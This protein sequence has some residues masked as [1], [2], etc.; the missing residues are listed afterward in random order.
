MARKSGRQQRSDAVAALIGAHGSLRLRDAARHIG[1]TEM[2]LRRDAATPDAPFRSLGG[3][4]VPAV[5]APD[6]DLPAEMDRH[7]EAKRAAARTA[8]PL[9]REGMRVFLDCGSTTIHLAQLLPG[10]LGLHVVTHSLTVAHIIA[11]RA[12]LDLTLLGGSYHPE[13]ASFHD[14]DI[15]PPQGLDLAFISAGGIAEDG[16]LSCS[17]PHEVAVK[18]AVLAGAARSYVLTDRSKLGQRRPV[19]F[20]TTAEI[21]GVVTEG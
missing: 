16:V 18:R 3:W 14:E 17:H 5:L 4:L 8:L 7:A 11:P 2:T 15:R 12:D 20:A 10:G 1:V 6:Y 19:P 13:T 21:A 9:L